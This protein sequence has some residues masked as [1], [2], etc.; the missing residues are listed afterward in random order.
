M[1]RKQC[2]NKQIKHED[3]SRHKR[4]HMNPIEISHD[5]VNQAVIFVFCLLCPLIQLSITDENKLQKSCRTNQAKL[6]APKHTA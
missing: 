4:S 3:T 5:K 2:K 1:N 6:R